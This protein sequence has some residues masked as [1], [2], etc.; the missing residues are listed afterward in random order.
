MRF[1]VIGEN[2]V[3]SLRKADAGRPSAVSSWSRYCL[4][5]EN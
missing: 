5:L 2:P 3:G 1:S 4:E